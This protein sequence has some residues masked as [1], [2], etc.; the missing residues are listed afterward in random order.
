MIATGQSINNLPVEIAMPEN[1][2]LW[3]PDSPHLY[4]LEVV[5]WDGNKQLDKVDSWAMRKY[6]MKRDNKGSCVYN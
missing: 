4:D 2:K 5:L 3:S 1:V 6:S